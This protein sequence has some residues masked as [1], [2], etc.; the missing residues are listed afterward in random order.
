MKKILINNKKNLFYIIFIYL[1]SAINNPLTIP[2][3][4]DINSTISFVRGVAPLIV[5]FFAI[6]YI[7]FNFRK[8]YIDKIYIFFFFISCISNSIFLL[9]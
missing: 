6:L 8:F 1:I 9:L 4:I 2:N 5:L 7:I 3:S